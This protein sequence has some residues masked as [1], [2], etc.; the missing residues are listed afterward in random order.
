MFHLKLSQRQ[1][2]EYYFLRCST[3][4]SSRSPLIFRRILL[5]PTSELKCAL[6]T[7]GS[8]GEFS[9]NLVETIYRWVT[10]SRYICSHAYLSF[11]ILVISC[12]SYET[13][14][15]EQYYRRLRQGPKV[16]CDSES[17][18]MQLISR[19]FFLM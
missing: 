19:Y 2:E 12:L 18:N 16:L 1:Y 6:I 7:F 11:I 3:I 15:E 8:T 10:S 13:L 9:R 4:Y 5:P 17:T 14:T